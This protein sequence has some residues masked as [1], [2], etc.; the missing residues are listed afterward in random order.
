[1]YTKVLMF[2]LG[3][4]LTSMLTAQEQWTAASGDWLVSGTSISQRDANDQFARIDVSLP[5]QDEIV[6]SFDVSYDDGGI[7]QNHIT[8]QGE[9]Q[10][11]FGIH[12][13]TTDPSVQS[14]TWGNGKSYLLWL[15]VDTREWTRE[16][17][18]EYYGLRAQV[19]K[20][21]N[22]NLMR[23]D[24]VSN[25]PDSIQ[26]WIPEN[27]LSIDLEKSV[28]KMNN[29]SYD[30]YD[31][32]RVYQNRRLPVR[33]HFNKVSGRVAV[34]DPTAPIAY[35]FYLDPEFLQGN[36]LSLRTNN[37]ALTFSHVKIQ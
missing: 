28:S 14:R 1:M 3:L 33:I 36:S 2:S 5:D 8:R 11:G 25:V 21:T 27:Y 22:K 9:L 7:A 13:G 20:S 10:G 18:S 35:V 23:L 15:N 29:A 24:Q 12:I 32:L 17:R 26:G 6:I 4:I 31:I 34:S 19:Y 16:N 30:L 37:L